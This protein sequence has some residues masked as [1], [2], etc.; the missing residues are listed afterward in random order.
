LI[1]DFE[2]P[3]VNGILIKRLR[4]EDNPGVRA[5]LVEAL[6]GRKADEG[7]ASKL[8]SIAVEE[9]SAR[10][11]EKMYLYIIRNIDLAEARKKL[12]ELLKTET[13]PANRKLLLNAIQGGKKR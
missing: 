7:S 6:A 8:I 1:K 5:A 10:T 13:S 2:D 12:P 9:K 3:G 4:K 11:R